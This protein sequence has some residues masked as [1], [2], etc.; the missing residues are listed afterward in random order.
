[1]LSELKVENLALIESL[2]LHFDQEEGSGLVV[3]TGETGAG[4]SI[5]L[6]AIHL[7][8]GGRAQVDWVRSGAQQC[9]VEA[10]FVVNANHHALLHSLQESGFGEDGTVVLKRVLASDGKSR[11]YVNGSLATV[12]MVSMLAANLLNIASQHDHQQ[13]LQPALHLDFLDSLGEHWEERSRFSSIFSQWQQKKEELSGLRRQERDKVQRRD[14]L[15]YQLEEIRQIGPLVGEDEELAAE[16]KRLKNADALIALSQK[17]YRFFSSTLVDGMFEVRRDIE[18]VVQ[19]DAEVEGLAADLTAYS[20]Q[21][22]DF[23]SRLRGYKD[24]LAHNPARLEQVNERINGLQHLKRKYGETLEAVLAYADSAESELQLLDNMDK[25]KS[26]LEAVVAKLEEE[27]MRQVAALSDRRRQTAGHLTQA[28]TA[29]LDSLAFSQSGFEVRFQEQGQG[30]ETIKNNGW[31]RVEFFFSANP[32]EPARPLAKV[33]SGGEL[34]R[35]MLAL[36]CL[37]AKKD[38]VETV[39]FD[40]VDAGIGGEAAEA[41]ARKIQELATHHQ[42]F[43][44]THLPQIAA[45]GNSH[46]LVAKQMEQ[47]RTLSSFSL[48]APEQRVDELARMLAGD[49]ASSQTRAWALELLA[50]G[51]RGR[52][53]TEPREMENPC[54]R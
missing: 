2:H 31:D 29:E 5:L 24:S 35:L 36:K 44:V 39:I 45:R 4:K 23:V 32:G 22:E 47:G 30:L 19:L 50:K 51:S 17:V 34:S 46:F 7:L 26:E 40:E 41:V 53:E 27:T 6:R 20:Y 37:L 54:P 49:S 28:M 3:M 11:L 38:M 8:M 9:V 21:V 16:R 48:L 1:M 43:C 25:N 13:L 42:V 33:A 18:Q 14:F 12:K 10:L 52:K 15:H